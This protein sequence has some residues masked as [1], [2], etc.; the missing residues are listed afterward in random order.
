MVSDVQGWI[1]N[2][3]SNFGWMLVNAQETTPATFRA[4]YSHETAT[5]ALRPQLSLTYVMAG[6]FDAND[7]VP[8]SPSMASVPEPATLVLACVAA[9]GMAA[10]ARRTRAIGDDGAPRS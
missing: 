5:A 3:A 9:L 8:A 6:D 1:E 4:F 2:P 7:V 10:T